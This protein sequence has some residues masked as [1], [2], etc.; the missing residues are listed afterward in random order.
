MHSFNPEIFL[1]PFTGHENTRFA[2]QERSHENT[3]CFFLLETFHHTGHCD[4]VD[5]I[6]PRP[7]V[8]IILMG[9]RRPAAALPLRPGPSATRPAAAL[10]LRAA[11]GG[12]LA[13]REGDAGLRRPLPVFSRHLRCGTFPVGLCASSSSTRNRDLVTM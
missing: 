11:T 1:F 5:L 13:P 10:L 8:R 7:A 4:G 12:S 6:L 2:A 3:F 9:F